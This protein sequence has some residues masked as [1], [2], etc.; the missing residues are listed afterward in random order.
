MKL[1]IGYKNV[2]FTTNHMYRN[3]QRKYSYVGLSHVQ[4]YMSQSIIILIKKI[5]RKSNKKRQ[6]LI[7]R[8]HILSRNLKSKNFQ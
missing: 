4:Y 3:E 5:S 1:S 6:L 2:L 8:K 7:I